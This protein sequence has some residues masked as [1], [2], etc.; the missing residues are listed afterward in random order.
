M[1][2]ITDVV[3]VK[4]AELLGGRM[5]S[6]NKKPDSDESGLAVVISGSFYPRR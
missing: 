6:E 1:L 2:V 4:P 5:N 3:E